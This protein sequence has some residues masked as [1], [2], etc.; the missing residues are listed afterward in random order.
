MYMNEKMDEGDI[1][2]QS[3]T[4]IS[5]DDTTE[6]LHDRLSIMG[7]DLILKAIPEIVSG[8]INRIKQNNPKI[9]LYIDEMQN[10]ANSQEVLKKAINNGDIT[11]QQWNNA[12]PLL[13][14]YGKQVGINISNDDVQNIEKEFS[15]VNNNF[16]KNRNN[17]NIDFRF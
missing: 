13:Q 9:A 3:S 2:L 1:I 11:R 14:K 12:K 17:K 7:R 5:L 15:N 6:T 16:N 10:G 4:S 8:N